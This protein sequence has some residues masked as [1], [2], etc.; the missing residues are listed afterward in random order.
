[1]KTSRY[2]LVA[3]LTVALATSCGMNEEPSSETAA[4]RTT[5]TADGAADA[6]TGGNDAGSTGGD[7][8]TGS[9][10][11]TA[12]VTE[13]IVNQTGPSTLPTTTEDKTFSDA[14]DPAAFAPTFFQ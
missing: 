11:F 14:E 12:F 3:S 7:G 1:M 4:V 5:P 10:K 13:L 8:R 9:Q 2:L 6:A